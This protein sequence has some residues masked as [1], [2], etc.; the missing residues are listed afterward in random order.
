MQWPYVRFYDNKPNKS[1]KAF[2]MSARKKYKKRP[3]LS[4]TIIKEDDDGQGTV[5]SK[6]VHNVGGFV[7]SCLRGAGTL[8]RGGDASGLSRLTRDGMA[9]DV[10]NI[11]ILC[12]L[13]LCSATPSKLRL[14][15]AAKL[16]FCLVSKMW[17]FVFHSDVA[18]VRVVLITITGD[19]G[20]PDFVWRFCD[21]HVIFSVHK[22]IVWLL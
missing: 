7:R 14:H 16:F 2:W 12:A 11:L 20:V 15:V 3:R 21:I 22:F 4:S 8:G 19:K 5:K 10:H 17:L 9:S 6:Y 1:R 13:V 18:T